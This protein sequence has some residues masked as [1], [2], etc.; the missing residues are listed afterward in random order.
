MYLILLT[1]RY[2][3]VCIFLFKN[4]VFKL[5]EVR[6]GKYFFLEIIFYILATVPT[7]S[8]ILLFLVEISKHVFIYKLSKF[9]HLNYVFFYN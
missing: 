8:P 2:D 9:L 4:F 5:I 6:Q 7:L 3:S 1:R